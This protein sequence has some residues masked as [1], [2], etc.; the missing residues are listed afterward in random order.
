MM[1]DHVFSE[2]RVSEI[3]GVEAPVAKRITQQIRNAFPDEQS[4][5][6][7]LSNAGDVENRGLIQRF[8]LEMEVEDAR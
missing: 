4:R 7:W 6:R 8:C 3:A 2:Q 1:F 5:L